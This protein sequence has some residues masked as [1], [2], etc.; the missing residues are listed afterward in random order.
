[1]RILLLILLFAIPTSIAAQAPVANAGPDRTVFVNE[2]VVLN[3]ESSTGAFDGLQPNSDNYSV[4]WDFGFQGWSYQSNLRGPVAYPKPGVYT[5]TLTVCNAAGTCAT[6]S[7]QVTVND[8]AEGVVTTVADTG[9]ATTNGT[10]LCNAITAR[11]GDANPVVQVVAGATYRMNC[12]LP[13]GVQRT[14]SG[15]MTIRSTGYASLPSGTT[16]VSPSDPNLA[17]FE[18]AISVAIIDTPATSSN[19][20]HHFRFLGI[21]WQKADPT[22][23]FTGRAFLNIG[24]GN[25]TALGQLPHH[26]IVDRCYFDG[27]STTS[28]TLR[29]IAIVSSD[30]SVVNSY[31]WR[32]KGPSL[33][34][35]AIFVGMGERIAVVNNYLQA[36]AE[37]MLIGGADP[38]ITGHV[39]TDVVVRRNLM[40]KDL[41][42]CA[43]CGSY[44]GVNMT[45]KNLWEAK[46][47]LRV[48]NQGNYYRIH[49]AEDQNWAI[50]VTVRNQ[51]GTAPWSKISYLDFSYNKVNR[52][53]EGTQILGF[54]DLN[55]SQSI[56]HILFR[57]IVYSGISFYNGRQ[58]T[59]TV[60]QATGGAADRVFIVRT[61][62]DSNGVDGQGRWVEFDTS[63]GFT[64]CIFVGNVAQGFINANGLTG[65]SGMQHACSTTSYSVVKNGFYLSTGTNPTGN[66]AVATRGD[67]K[68]TDVSNFD[69]FLRADSP[70]LTTGLSGG[71]E[72][73]DIGAVDALTVGCVTGL[74]PDGG[75]V[76][77]G[78]KVTLAG[79]TNQ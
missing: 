61:S 33:E 25:E 14:G 10:N 2:T 20:T 36:G 59:F 64:N 32:F 45:V 8:I 74:W 58:N 53:A 73:A 76:V 12:V 23:T 43:F 63:T 69:L 68:F 75:R 67:V 49:W 27:G 70:F 39:P 21:H 19:P 6:D 78:G 22:A 16:R 18:T 62:S 46:L 66:T 47:G 1:M 34:T 3:G 48:S 17:I 51:D 11:A 71:R 42:W 30:T 79:K 72:G 41:G 35:Q 60:T 65:N 29:G 26:F 4:I 28:S 50:T 44:Y 56:D 52:I 13:T 55:T 38:R 7:T 31:M 54:D 57:H 37:N 15:Y 24:Q 40:E 77:L 5:A 9:N